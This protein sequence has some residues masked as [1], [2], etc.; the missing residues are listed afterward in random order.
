MDVKSD[1]WV[2]VLKSVVLLNLIY[3]QDKSVLLYSFH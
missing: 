3:S 2:I 1:G